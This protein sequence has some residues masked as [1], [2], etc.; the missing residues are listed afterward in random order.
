MSYPGGELLR[1]GALFPVGAGEAPCRVTGGD[2]ETDEFG[3][4][5]TAEAGFVTEGHP[6]AAVG[7]GATLAEQHQLD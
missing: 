1:T 3:D 4:F 2:R 7:G 6:S 5:E